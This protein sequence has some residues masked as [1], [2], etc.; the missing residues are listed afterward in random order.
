MLLL[1]QL[2][3]TNW[4]KQSYIYYILIYCDNLDS[5]Q[6]AEETA[7][8]WYWWEHYY[9][10]EL[11]WIQLL[12]YHGLQTCDTEKNKKW[13][14]GFLVF[15][16]S[17]PRVLKSIFF[18]A[19]MFK[20]FSFWTVKCVK[21]SLQSQ[22]CLPK[23]WCLKWNHSNVFRM[24]LASFVLLRCLFSMQTVPL[25]WSVTSWDFLCSFDHESVQLL[26]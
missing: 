17:A 21:D 18:K 4:T 14:L 6:T 26:S 8:L 10:L 12:Q 9:N 3:Q 23:Q 5:M 11:W 1:G 7:N 24:N 16:I 13:T 20:L 19:V 22:Y 15:L 2:R 25:A